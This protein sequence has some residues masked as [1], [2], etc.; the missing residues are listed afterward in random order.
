MLKAVN[1]SAEDAQLLLNLTKNV[2]CMFNLIC[3]NPH[4]GTPF[5]YGAGVPSCP[6][7]P[8]SS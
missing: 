3:F 4:Q 8:S 7:C 2:Y 1:D 6:R 5:R